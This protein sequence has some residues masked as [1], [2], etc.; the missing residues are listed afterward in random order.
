MEKQVVGWGDDSKFNSGERGS[1]NVTQDSG[2]F[3][4]AFVAIDHHA[5]AGGELLK[6]GADKS[7]ELPRQ[8]LLELLS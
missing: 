7:A 6:I 4:L 8:A 1:N 2:D 3:F 5:V